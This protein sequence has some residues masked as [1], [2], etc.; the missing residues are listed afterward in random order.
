MEINEINYADIRNL[1]HPD[2]GKYF[3]FVDTSQPEKGDII[4]KYGAIAEIVGGRD[5]DD[6]INL[7]QQPDSARASAHMMRKIFC[8]AEWDCWGVPRQIT[9]DL[10]AGMSIEDARDKI[11]SYALEIF[12]YTKPQYMPK[13][14]DS[15]F[16]RWSL[17]RIVNLDDFL[18]IKVEKDGRE[19]KSTESS[20]SE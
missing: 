8:A 6:L 4:A 18:K 13:K 7:V 2:F 16:N 15:D 19:D 3:R 1:N 14:E 5:K 11:Y 20:V 10:V 17:I 9:E 12:F